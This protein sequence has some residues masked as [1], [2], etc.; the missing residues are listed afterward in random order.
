MT[1][2]GHLAT[3]LLSLQPGISGWSSMTEVEACRQTKALHLSQGLAVHFIAINLIWVF[4]LKILHPAMNYGF[5]SEAS[6][7]FLKN[8][9]LASQL[10]VPAKPV[11]SELKNPISSKETV[12][13]TKI[14]WPTC[15]RWSNF[16]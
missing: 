7:C 12:P 10:F 3:L 1:F 8:V 11:P 16:R 15:C 2:P 9:S 14:L 5:L 13:N 6:N 4:D